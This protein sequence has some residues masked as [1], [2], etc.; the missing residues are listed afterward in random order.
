MAT[1][2][3]P[4]LQYP[5]EEQHN[6]YEERLEAVISGWIDEYAFLSDAQKQFYK[7]CQFGLISSFFYPNATWE[8]L[9]V[10]ARLV[11]LL[12]I[13]DD[14]TDEL[15]PDEL[16]SF[17]LKSESIMAGHD[18]GHDPES[19]FEE[20]ILLREGLHSFV[21]P[22][23]MHRWS[24]NLNYFYEG[25]IMERYFMHAGQY[26]AVQHYMFVREHLIGMYIFQD[27]VELYLPALLP[28]EILSHPH[29]RQLRQVASRIIAWCNDYYSAAKE[30]ESGQT[31]NLV[32]VIKE[33]RQCSMEEAHAVAVRI[34]EEEIRKFMHLEDH[35]PDF[36][37]Y[38]EA[39]KTYVR[40]L[41]LMFKGNH[42]W[43]VCSGRYN[44]V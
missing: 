8:A 38:N 12:F 44:S 40:E 16:R 19:I 6:Q 39:F 10:G 35:L 21:P 11:V 43:H 31:T 14:V 32:L 23:W 25:M 7:Q 30:L 26:P 36:G 34:H 27:I 3:F 9:L 37:S 15:P 13:H 20:F 28:Y 24:S 41:R 42:M 17:L 2:V 22:E 1:Q 4:Q 33:E 29:T 5:F 18:I